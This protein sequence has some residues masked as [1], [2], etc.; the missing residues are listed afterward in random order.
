QLCAAL[1]HPHI[2]RLIDSGEFAG[3]LLY[4]VFE[5]IPG[6]TLR[7]VLQV[8]HKLEPREAVH[9]MIQV[10]DGLGCAHDKGVV[11]RDL[12]PENIMVTRTG[13]RRNA[14]VLDFG[15]GGFCAATPLAQS[16]RL[17]ETSVIMGT[18]SYAAPEQLRG[19]PPTPRSDLYSWGLTLLE[20]L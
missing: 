5:Y 10:L 11:H 12:K 6:T 14:T 17:T 3:G 13:L 9:L 8:E 7:Q 20:C 2:V 16:V 18:P 1:S 4:V 19:E 15:L